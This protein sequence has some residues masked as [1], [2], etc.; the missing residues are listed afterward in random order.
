MKKIVFLLISFC[1]VGFMLTSCE[2]V[3]QKSEQF[4]SKFDAAI[5]EGNL[6]VAKNVVNESEAYYNG[7]SENNKIKYNECSPNYKVLLKAETYKKEFLVAAAFAKY[8]EQSYNKCEKIISD[9]K[10][11][12]KTLSEEDRAVFAE[13]FNW[14]ELWEEFLVK[15]LAE[16][17]VRSIHE[18]VK[19]NKESEAQRLSN[20]SDSVLESLNVKLQK[21]YKNAAEAE[22]NRLI[23]SDN[24]F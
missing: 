6:A 1:T 4:K 17:Y 10:K 5:K 16:S 8:D 22:A 18:C 23:Q 15:S 13:V 11:Y 12:I 24:S 9:T 7:L 21:V 19:N 3:Q 2:N 20:E 14:E